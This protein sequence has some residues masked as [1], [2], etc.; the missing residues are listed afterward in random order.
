MYL[1]LCIKH[2]FNVFIGIYQP[3]CKNTYVFLCLK[4]EIIVN[5]IHRYEI[6]SR[7]V[8]FMDFK[9]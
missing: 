8:Y 3:G 2:V 6:I 9:R 4:V 7:I 1:P 5:I